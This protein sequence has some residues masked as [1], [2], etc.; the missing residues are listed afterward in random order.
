[1]CELINDHQLWCSTIISIIIM[2]YRIDTLIVLVS[3]ICLLL[4][5][6][7]KLAFLALVRP[8]KLLRYHA[9]PSLLSLSDSPGPSLLPLSLYIWHKNSHLLTC[10]A[11]SWDWNVGTGI[12]C[13]L[14]SIWPQKCWQLQSSLELYTTSLPL[15][16]LNFSVE[17]C[18]KDAGKPGPLLVI[19]YPFLLKIN[20]NN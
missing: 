8:I 19:A 4:E 20:Y 15:L 16:A 5:V 9:P 3:L 17:K 2:P 13:P 11:G 6:D 14:S 12:S 18:L 1:M 10:A 7:S